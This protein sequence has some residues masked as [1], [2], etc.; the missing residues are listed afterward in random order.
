[1][2]EDVVCDTRPAVLRRLFMVRRAVVGESAYPVD[3]PVS[4]S[5]RLI[6]LI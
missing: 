2:E 1:M 6:S 4:Y 3:L 5:V